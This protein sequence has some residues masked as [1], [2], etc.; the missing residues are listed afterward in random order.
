MFIFCF[1]HVE[2]VC[3]IKK[4]KIFTITPIGLRYFIILIKL[5]GMKVVSLKEVVNN[6][7]PDIL[8]NNRLCAITFDDG[9]EN[10][11]QYGLPV[12]QSLKC[13][14]TIFILGEKFSGFNDW[15][16]L[17]YE[18]QSPDALL[19]FKQMLSMAETGLIHYGS[20]GLL[21]R[22]MTKLDT[23]QLRA[24]IL[25]SYQILAYNL[26]SYFIPVFAY[27]WGAYTQESEKILSQSDYLLACT[28][29]PGAFTSHSKKFLIPRYSIDHRFSNPIFTILKLIQYRMGIFDF[30]LLL[31]MSSFLN[32]IRNFQHI[33]TRGLSL[34][35]KSES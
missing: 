27:P 13:P 23:P 11:L 9:Y 30:N 14:A 32:R 3:K 18:G 15:D 12:L 29:D 31:F 28:T 25:D 17:D 2:P 6:L 24:E 8:N 20:H 16:S 5:I 26:Q 4:R 1:H 33:L 35:T 34:R 10:V 7:S 22:N 21:H 19:S